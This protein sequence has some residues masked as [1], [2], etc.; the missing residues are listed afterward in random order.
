VLCDLD[1][2]V[3]AGRLTW[4]DLIII[5]AP[6]F[7]LP[8]R[9]RVGMREA[10]ERSATH[11]RLPFALIAQDTGE[12]LLTIKARAV[13]CKPTTGTQE[14]CISVTKTVTGSVSVTGAGG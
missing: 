1:L 9:D 12:G 5:K 14:S 10:S 7:A 4:A 8:L 2:D 3:I 13:W 6:G 11:L